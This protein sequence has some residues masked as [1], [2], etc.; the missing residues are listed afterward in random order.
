[1]IVPV[2]RSARASEEN[3]LPLIN[4]VFLLLIFFMMAGALSVTSPLP[5]DPPRVAAAADTD[6]PREGVVIA[7]DGRIGFAGETI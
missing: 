2:P 7:A 6:P 3:V 4:I 5:L 1:M